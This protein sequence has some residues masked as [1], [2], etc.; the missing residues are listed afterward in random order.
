MFPAS[1]CSIYNLSKSPEFWQNPSQFS[2]GTESNINLH[3]IMFAWFNW[4]ILMPSR[5]GYIWLQIS[6][7]ILHRN[8]DL[9]KRCL[10]GAPHKCQTIMSA[11]RLIFHYSGWNYKRFVLTATSTGIEEAWLESIYKTCSA[12]VTGPLVREKEWQIY[13]IA[14]GPLCTCTIREQ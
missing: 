14:P 2:F 11:S 10:S 13:E 1:A 3:M 5:R 7:M 4:A 9:G 12:T 6:H 8:L